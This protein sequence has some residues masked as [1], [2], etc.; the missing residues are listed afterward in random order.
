MSFFNETNFNECFF[1]QDPRVL[2]QMLPYMTHLYGNPHSRTH[3]FGWEGEKA[4]EDARDVRSKL[5]VFS[6]WKPFVFR[7]W[8]NWSTLI[9]KKSFLPAGQ[10]NRI[11]SLL[12]VLDDFTKRKRNT[13]WR[14]K[15]FVSFFYVENRFSS[16]FSFS[17]RNTNVFWI[18]CVYWKAKVSK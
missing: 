12:K 5:D 4:V 14:P 6:K 1:L 11:T 15:Q 17:F 7:K 2:D 10:L 18:R 16:T 3:A 9:R 8:R 13:S